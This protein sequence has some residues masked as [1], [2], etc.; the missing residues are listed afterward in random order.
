MKEMVGVRIWGWSFRITSKFL[1]NSQILRF[2]KSPNY[3]RWLWDEGMK[4]S[5]ERTIE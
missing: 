3:D 1:P 5:L 2:Y 4:L